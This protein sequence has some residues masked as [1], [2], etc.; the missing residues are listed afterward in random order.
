VLTAFLF[1]YSRAPASLVSWSISQQAFNSAMILLLDALETNNLSHI[2]QVEQAYAVFRELQDNEVHKLAGLAVEKLS[3]GLDQLRQNM[4]G[5]PHSP[6]GKAEAIATCF[7]DTIMAN[8]GMYIPEDPGL[9]SYKSEQF[10]PL[11]WIATEAESEAATPDRFKK[12]QEQPPRCKT[13]VSS[14]STATDQSEDAPIAQKL[15]RSAE[16]PQE[17]VSGRPLSNKPVQTRRCATA[18]ASPKGLAELTHLSGYKGGLIATAPC[19][20]DQEQLAHL[21]HNSQLATA[22]VA[23]A[24]VEQSQTG[25]N[26][27][28]HRPEEWAHTNPTA[29]GGC[30]PA[31]QHRHNSC[32][33]THLSATTTPHL[34]STYSSPLANREAQTPIN[35]D[36]YGVHI[37]WS[38]S[39]ATPTLHML[40]PEMCFTPTSEK[41]HAVQAFDQHLHQQQAA[42]R[43]G[44]AHHSTVSS[45][46]GHPVMAAQHMTVDQW[47]QWVG[48]G[49]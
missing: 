1:F 44:F 10:A 23:V 26:G 4:E 35:N 5:A 24:C 34:Q 9:Q 46:D 7:Y 49:A 8:T 16:S 41:V 20:S 12:E 30:Q 36:S 42:Y 32:P 31:T 25:G 6:Q 17:S 37:P 14:H 2:I 33:T 27:D 13:D 22:R 19:H 48:S 3:W 18:L 11:S 28:L 38:A 45:T 39:S 47:T 29:R 40:E 21:P 15:Q 43:Y